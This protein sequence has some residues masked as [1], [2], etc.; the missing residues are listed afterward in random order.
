MVP[1]VL[2][3]GNITVKTYVEIVYAATRSI[4]VVKEKSMFDVI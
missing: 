2:Y 3:C 1:K 4:A